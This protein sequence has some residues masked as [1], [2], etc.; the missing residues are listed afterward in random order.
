VPYIGLFDSPPR[1]VALILMAVWAFVMAYLMWRNS[2]RVR[3]ARPE[4]ASP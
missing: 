3:V 1:G 4:S 2:S